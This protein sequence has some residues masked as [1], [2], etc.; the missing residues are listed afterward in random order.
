MS[1]EVNVEIHEDEPLVI[2]ARLATDDDSASGAATGRDGEGYFLQQ[3]DFDSIS[4]SIFDKDSSTPGTA[5]DT[6][7][8]TIADVI[9]DTP[10][11]TSTNVL[12]T[13][14]EYG[15]NFKHKLSH[16]YF[17][18][19]LRKYRIE[20]VAILSNADADPIRWSAE[21]QSHPQDTN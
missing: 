14:D 4:C 19:G 11:D 2:M 3:A 13:N 6:A 17:P 8:L 7:S 16:T 9:F 18:N 15:Y 5:S 20:Y 12:W 1:F 10:K 21:G